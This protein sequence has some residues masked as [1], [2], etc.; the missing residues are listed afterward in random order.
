MNNIN[1][2]QSSLYMC[3]SKKSIHAKVKIRLDRGVS[4]VEFD[5]SIKSAF[6][7]GFYFKIMQCLCYIPVK[8]VESISYARG[9]STNPENAE[10]HENK[11]FFPV[12]RPVAL[13]HNPQ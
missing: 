7:W 12:V 13:R 9:C 11:C 5:M 2:S 3:V 4:N 6:I 8:Y 1:V 10:L